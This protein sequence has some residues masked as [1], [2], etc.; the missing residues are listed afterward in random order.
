[1]IR[2][3]VNWVRRDK[4]EAAFDRELQYHLDSR[5]SDLRAS[6]LSAD[7]ARRQ[8]VLE[9]GGI[10]HVQEEVRDI[11]L[12]RWIRDFVY[13]LRFSLRSL[14]KNPAFSATAVLSLSLGV[15]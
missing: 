3:L 15:G 2:Q 4:L 11:W 10:A 7:E 1:M 13:D 6:G 14:Y 5:M 9:L 12:T 8:T